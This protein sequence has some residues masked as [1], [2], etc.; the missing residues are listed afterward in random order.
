MRLALAGAILLVFSDLVAGSTAAAAEELI[1][2]GATP[3]D[4]WR[5]YKDA[6]EAEN[7]DITLNQFMDTSGALIARIIA[8]RD[9]PRADVI[10]DMPAT[11]I[12][13]LEQEGLIEPYAPSGL[14]EIDPR[15]ADQRDPPR[16]FAYSGFA[17][18]VC[19]NRFEGDARSVPAPTSW[20][21][22]TDPVYRGQITMADPNSSG[23]GMMLV[24]GFLQLFGEEEGWK[25]L[26]QLHENIAFYTLGG[27]KPCK[28]AGAGEYALGL[29]LE[30]TAIAE[31]E[32]G[33]P[34]DAVIPAEGLFWDVAAV[35]MVKGTD[36]PDAARRFLDWASSR[37]AN[38]LYADF[39]SIVAISD[40]AKPQPHMPANF[41]EQ[42]RPIDLQWLADN[43]ERI[44][45]EWQR[46]Y[47]T[48]VEAE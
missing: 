19:Y 14:S 11:A 45:A 24:S 17:A 23:V 22:L 6:F 8:E 26:D 10:F 46:R 43:R 30:S 7:P 4:E 32:S 20:Q 12:V 42:L 13:V 25:F 18:L 31:I 1:V 48:K 47:A 2:Y 37:S 21:D 29:S 38:R 3:A 28:L 16:W 36:N 40:A 9:S 15:L 5:V 27:R 34:I 39:W 35:G 41:L 33:A 44:G